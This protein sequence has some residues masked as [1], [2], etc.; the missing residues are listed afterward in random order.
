[1]AIFSEALSS[2]KEVFSHDFV[3]SQR[4]LGDHSFVTDVFELKGH[5]ANVEIST[6]TNLDNNWAYFNFAF[7]NQDTGQAYDFGREVS[8]YQGSDSDGPWTEGSSS[9]DAIVP[10]VPEGRYYLRVEPE[11]DINAPPVAYQLRVRRGVPSA[12]IFGIA[13]LLLV[14][15]PVF[16]TFRSA[17]FETRRWQESDYA[18]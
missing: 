17:S 4:A 11:M 3:Y 15:P 2:R 7:I 1:M 18:S 13:V 14:L 6:R 8:Y 16:L 12:S 9:D 5:P 10:G